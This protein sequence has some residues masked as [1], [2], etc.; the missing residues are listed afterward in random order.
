MPDKKITFGVSIQAQEFDQELN[1]IEKR[2]NSFG[3]DTGFT[4]GLAKLQPQLKTLG[5]NVDKAT[6]QLFGDRAQKGAKNLDSHIKKQVKDLQTLQN[7]ENQR[8]NKIKDF[9]NRLKGL[10]NE[11]KNYKDIQQSI[12]DLQDKQN[13]NLVTQE[14]KL[15]SIVKTSG[16]LKSIQQAMQAGTGVGVDAG[17]GRLNMMAQIA[18]GALK[19]G[20]KVG[21]VTAGLAAPVI[22][23]AG[24]AA[25][26]Y[27]YQ[28]NIPRIEARAE[29]QTLRGIQRTPRAFLEGRGPEEMLFQK[30]NIL[31]RS[32]EQA[33]K[34]IDAERAK[35]KALSTLGMAG[36]GTAT[37][38]GAGTG[39]VGGA[40]IGQ[41]FGGVGALPGA[42][43]GGVGGGALT[44][45]SALFSLAQTRAGRSLLNKDVYNKEINA[46]TA[47]EYNRF[48]GENKERIE[49]Q[50]RTLNYMKV[51]S[52][53]YLNAQRMLGFQDEDL[54]G[55]LKAIRSQEPGLLGQTRGFRYDPGLF[56]ENVGFE[57]NE[58]LN[59][60]RN[61]AQIGGARNVRKN[62][63]AAL[64]ARR[65][66]NIMGGGQMIGQLQAIGGQGD[67]EFKKVL[68]EGMTI[69]L[70]NS[71]MSREQERF[72]STVTQMVF[73]QGRGTDAGQMASFMASLA[74]QDPTMRALA[75]APGAAAGLERL[76]RN[77][78]GVRGMLQAAQIE[79]EFQ[80]TNLDIFGKIA[81]QDTGVQE[82]ISGSA[83]ITN[84]AQQ[85]GFGDNVD[86]FRRKALET[87][88]RSMTITQEAQSIVEQMRSGELTG[89]ALEGIKG[90]LGT[91]MRGTS[92]VF[93]G[94][95]QE[96]QRQ[97]LNF[98]Q[99][100]EISE[101][102][103]AGVDLGR[104]EDSRRVGDM[105]SR[106]SSAMEKAFRDLFKRDEGQLRESIQ[107]ATKMA[108][109]AVEFGDR[110]SKEFK[111]MEDSGKL[112]ADILAKIN[113]ELGKMGTAPEVETGVQT[114][115]NILDIIGIGGGEQLFTP[116]TTNQSLPPTTQEGNK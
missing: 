2:L 57:E 82:I 41:A 107:G 110:L 116:A 71:D 44:G 9:Q 86:E 36:V 42:I 50:R 88:T 19:F 103:R 34:V 45:G 39:V 18:K 73:Q 101:R 94:M 8:T 84:L 4:A 62:T 23:G 75:A 37:A 47:S 56:N 29:A 108:P 95:D 80:G 85:A 5:I 3:R 33:R 72:A 7:I 102:R 1:R 109:L 106:A 38:A 48:I 22:A 59:T 16:Q 76:T 61:I 46:L 51:R 14:A 99:T 90:R 43:I 52:P 74:G 112:A 40:V 26:Y 67:E 12:V 89:E 83:R 70:N 24:L 81:L 27:Q 69:G 78:A 35:D 53:S 92:N 91:I 32:L 114:R 54:F 58:I 11:S 10:N 79:R 96:Q 17:V 93:A 64:L 68:A 105:F 77:T 115:Q 66:L 15:S 21:A 55:G 113:V 6:S 60:A 31:Q 30:T 111:K 20:G 28:A 100:G 13:K 98:L 49:L 63:R 87:K 97:I 25:Q 65:N 104:P